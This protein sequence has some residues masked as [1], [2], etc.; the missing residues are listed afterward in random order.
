MVEISFRFLP[1]FM[2]FKRHVNRQSINIAKFLYQFQFAYLLVFLS[3]VQSQTTSYPQQVQPPSQGVKTKRGLFG[4]EDELLGPPPPESYQTFPYVQHK[5]RPIFVPSTPPTPGPIYVPSTPSPGVFVP[6]MNKWTNTFGFDDIN[7]QNFYNDLNG[8]N[9]GPPNHV[10]SPP[11]TAVPSLFN[12][13]FGYINYGSPYDFETSYISNDG[14]ILKQ[15]SVHERHHNDHPNPNGFQLLPSIPTQA[16]PPAAV[17]A[18]RVPGL[19]RPLFVPNNVAQ[20]R[21]FFPNNQP[22]PNG[23]QSF[24]TSNHGPVAFGSG[25]LGFVQLP[26]GDVFLGSGSKSY[27]SHKDHYDNVIE[28]TNRRQKSHPRGP[29]TFGHLQL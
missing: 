22:S 14:R 24:L 26:N 28:I 16:A 15:Y 1:F 21:N 29:T 11:P 8:F 12:N 19:T 10:T 20:P 9:Y 27:I 7:Y 2:R 25:G 23:I 3:I 4:I 13:G 18:Q 5:N 6:N 17:P